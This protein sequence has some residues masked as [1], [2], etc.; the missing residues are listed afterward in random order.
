MQISKKGVAQE[1]EIK[2]FQCLYQV[3]ADLKKPEDVARFL[4]DVLSETERT[5]LAKRLAI[6]YWLNKNKSY[7]KIRQELRVSSATVANVQKWLEKSGEGLKLALKTIDA[8]EWAGEMAEKFSA[9][10]RSIFK[11]K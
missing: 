10:V 6:A 2:I 1:T 5:V 11:V 9:K 7:D 8:D 3:L 4:E